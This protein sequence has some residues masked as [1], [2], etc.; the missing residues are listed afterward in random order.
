[1][2]LFQAAVFVLLICGAA[3]LIYWA[4]PKLGTP[5]PLARIVLVLTMVIAI[6]AVVFVI[7]S[8]IGMAGSFPTPRVS[9]GESDLQQAARVAWEV[10]H[11]PGCL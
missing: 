10:T 7:L 9:W 1:M 5:E 11:S 6:V 4:V 8:L 2:T 3:A